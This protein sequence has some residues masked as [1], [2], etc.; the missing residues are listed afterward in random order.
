[1][2]IIV[3]LGNPGLKYGGTRH[4]TGF[5]VLKSFAKKHGIGIKKKGFNGVYGIGKVFGQEIML[6]EP[7][8]YMNLSGEA[9]KAVCA[10][11]MENLND[12][13]VVTDDFSLPIGAIRLREKG[14]S[15]G[16]NGLS[17]IIGHLGSDFTRIRVGIAS[18]GFLSIDEQISSADKD[19]ASYVLSNFSRKEKPDLSAAV[20]K[21]IECIEIW[22]GSGAK[23]AMNKCNK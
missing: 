4:N 1:M 2:K 19:T 21:A 3:G 15:G 14:S 7:L 13:L 23:E 5:M 8:T 18:E 22:L 11:K 12:L 16:H 20:E 6:F 10:S 17:S 9:V